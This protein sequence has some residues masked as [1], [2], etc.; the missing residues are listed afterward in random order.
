MALQASSGGLG[1]GDGFEQ[2]LLLGGDG[3]QAVGRL[4]LVQR[5]LVVLDP[6]G[7]LQS[8]FRGEQL[9]SASSV[10]RRICDALGS[11]GYAI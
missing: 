3:G 4:A 1:Q 9:C 11:K 7:D 5:D 2:L 6:A 10:F 8:A